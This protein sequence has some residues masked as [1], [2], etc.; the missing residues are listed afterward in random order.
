MIAV[1][2]GRF[3]SMVKTRILV[4]VGGMTHVHHHHDLWCSNW[5][6]VERITWPGHRVENNNSRGAKDLVDIEN[7]ADQQRPIENQHRSTG[8]FS[9]DGRAPP[10]MMMTSR[11]E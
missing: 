4:F 10:P 6:E 5:K 1:I 9:L 3:L 2:W 7:D 8:S 11:C